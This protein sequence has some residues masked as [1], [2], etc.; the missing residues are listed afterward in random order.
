MKWKIAAPHFFNGSKFANSS[1]VADFRKMSK[2]TI[3]EK[4]TG[5]FKI[6]KVRELALQIS[7]TLYIYIY[8]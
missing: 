2:E 8:L 5:D 3:W 7:D 6:R 1:V 4:F